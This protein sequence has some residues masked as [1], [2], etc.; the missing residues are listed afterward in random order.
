MYREKDFISEMPKLRKFAFRLTGDAA[1]A[2]DLLQATALR[3]LEKRRLFQTGT[4]LFSWASKIMFNIFATEYR[5][6]KKFESRF[7][8]ESSLQN[9]S[10]NPPQET[11]F[12][13]GRVRDA[14]NRLPAPHKEILIM[15]C[16]R[17]MQYH[18]VSEM[19]KIPVG[20]VRSRLSRARKGLQ[21]L[22]SAGSPAFYRHLP[23]QA[24][25]SLSAHG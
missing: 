1:Q 13:L 5:K 19:L 23:T 8:P 16:I 20:T 17:D 7:D 25:A 18:E 15:V 12:D 3:A 11:A 24:G 21:D 14:M 10:V 9:A 2:D 6:R 22:L 4:N